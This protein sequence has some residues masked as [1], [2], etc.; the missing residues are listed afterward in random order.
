MTGLVFRFAPTANRRTTMI[1]LKMTVFAAFL[2]ALM[3]GTSLAVVP[4]TL[5]Y[6]GTLTDKAGNPISATRT[7][8][9]R[10]YNIDSGGTALWAETQT[11]TVTGGRFG[12]VL[13][14][15]TSL[16]P[17]ILSGDTWL[18]IGVE[19][20][21]EMTPRQ[22]LTS[23]AYALKAKNAEAADSVT[24]TDSIIP[25]GVVVAFG[26]TTAPEGWLLCDGRSFLRTDYPRLFAAIGSAHGTADGTHFNIPDYRGRFLRGVD[27]TAGI[28]PSAD[29]AA[30]TAMKTGGN[31][32]NNV[33]SVQTDGFSTHNHTIS[34]LRNNSQS[35][36]VIGGGSNADFLGSG[37]STTSVGGNETRPKNAYV[38]W[39]IKY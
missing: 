38:N 30:R 29:K 24:S 36:Q 33:G 37:V 22:K 15:S 20:E 13:G 11:L 26:G 17:S 32:G 28:E 18:G 12:A 9:F 19:G 34:S 10:L 39:I 8:V 7:I 25:P 35:S 31:T 23:V 5:S 6:Q 27:G 3:A 4:S 21:P 1:S 2:L 14:L 16:D